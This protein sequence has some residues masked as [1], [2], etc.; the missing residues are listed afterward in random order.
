MN[1]VQSLQ[2]VL[3]QLARES[4]SSLP[5]LRESGI[6]DEATLEAVMLFQRDHHPPV[7]GVVDE[8]L[9]NAIM[10]AYAGHLI[11]RS[12]PPP[13]RVFPQGFAATPPGES[14]DAVLLAQA[15]FTALADSFSN[16]EVCPADRCNSGATQRNILALQEAA[17][18]AESAGTLDRATWAHLV[19]L[20]EALV[21]RQALA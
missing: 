10:D 3:N 13:L 16:L 21:T 9:W 4:P 2:Y 15:M 20:Y 17:L 1:P 12:D 8:A 11:H 18:L 5:V 6:F 7:T 14:S 19:R